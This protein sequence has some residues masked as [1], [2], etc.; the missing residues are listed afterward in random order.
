MNAINRSQAV[1][2]TIKELVTENRDRMATLAQSLARFDKP[3]EGQEAR[4][5]APHLSMVST[6][7]VQ[8]SAASPKPHLRSVAAS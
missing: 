4:A 3:D 5:D 8:P 6:T 1:G 2:R 7:E